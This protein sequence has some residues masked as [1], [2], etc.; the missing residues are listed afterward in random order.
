[1]NRLIHKFRVLKTSWGIAIDID[2]SFSFKDRKI[3]EDIELDL[4][5]LDIPI[6]QQKYLFEGLKWIQHFIKEP[7]II[8]VHALKH[9]FTDYQDEALCFAFAEWAS[10]AF[11]FKIPCYEVTYDREE[12]KYVFKIKTKL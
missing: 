3:N 12:Y 6:F 5:E 4:S 11:N 2:A 8:V 7:V 1:M 9:N 10:S